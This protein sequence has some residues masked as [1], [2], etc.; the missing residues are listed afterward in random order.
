MKRIVLCVLALA[1]L[2]WL[3][4]F[5]R[6]AP[7]QWS[8]AELARIA[9]LVLPSRT[10]LRQQ[11]IHTGNGVWNDLAAV[12]L[13]EALFFDPRLS[14]N[15]E[16][17]C[18]SCHRPRDSF[19]DPAVRSQGIG[20]TARHTPSLLGTALQHWQF[21]DGRADSLWAQ[22]L[23][24]LEDPA[25]HGANRLQLAHL[26][27]S[28]YAPRYR[29]VFGEL[30]ALQGLPEH[31]TPLGDNPQWQRNWQLLSE[32]Q[33]TAVDRVFANIGKSLAAFQS[34]ILPSDTRFDRFAREL[35]QEGDSEQLS[36]G[37]QKGLKL[38]INDER[39][40]CLRCHNGPMFSN[41][42]F[43]VTG[44]R[45]IL[46]PPGLGRERGIVQAL[47]SRFNCRSSF[48]D[49]DDPELQCAE[50]DFAKRTG[51]ELRYAF[52]VPT[53]RNIGNT[54]PYMHNG[55]LASLADVLHFYARAVPQYPREREG[56]RSR[57]SGYG[58]HLDIEPLPLASTQ[59]AQL[60][61]F[62]RT[63]DSER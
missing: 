9:T 38:F 54:A 36:R 56:E 50:L 37:E 13:G 22:A 61:A 15:G 57:N 2:A 6:Q 34:H 29:A 42:D 8:D 18:A 17:S 59:L 10:E 60:E 46:T 63:L 24:P 41:G 30:P 21:W 11:V 43:Q 35:L 33:R 58:F 55:S 7:I 32:P 62:L 23:G 49:V 48:A 19:A 20:L 4:L 16:V 51:D 39:G 47:D 12:K 27:A 5:Q 31:A 40:Q 44:I 14:A 26:I 52:K 3:G 28:A 45:D 1:I 53:L 25:E